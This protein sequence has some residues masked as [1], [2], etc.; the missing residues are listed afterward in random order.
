MDKFNLTN[1]LSAYE[2][3]E[4]NAVVALLAAAGAYLVAAGLMF[5]MPS[6]AWIVGIA[7]LGYVANTLRFWNITDDTCE[8]VNSAWRVFLWLN[9]L[10][11][12]I[13]TISLVWVYL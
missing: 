7:G 5:A 8:D 13:V 12:A 3:H 4:A 6:P 9:Y 11:G 10:V 2:F 1:F